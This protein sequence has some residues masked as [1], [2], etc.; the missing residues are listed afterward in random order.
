MNR[1]KM[2]LININVKIFIVLSLVALFLCG[3]IVTAVT[4]IKPEEEWIQSRRFLWQKPPE[5]PPVGGYPVLFILHGSSCFAESWFWAGRGLY[6]GAFI[7][8]RQQTKFVE[9]ALERGYF[10]IASDSSYLSFLST[11]VKA[12]DASTITFNES[13]DLPFIQGILDWLVDHPPTPVNISRLYCA[14]FSSGG[15]MTSRIAHLFGSRFKAVAIH[16]ATNANV[17]NWR[18]DF[19]SPQNF[20]H[21]HPPTLVIQGGKDGMMPAKAAIHFYEELQKNGISSKLLYKPN[22]H[23]IWYSEFNNQI[24]DWFDSN[25]NT[26]AENNHGTD[27]LPLC[28]SY[29]GTIL[30]VGGSGPN[31][32]SKIQDAI[33]NASTGDTVFVYDD[34]S[35]Y[36]ENIIIQKGVNLIGEN[37]NSTV[38]DGSENGDVINITADN[39]FLSRFTVQNCG[40]TWPY[41]EIHIYGNKCTITDNIITHTNPLLNNTLNI[42]TGI[43]MYKTSQNRITN[44]IIS[45]HYIGILFYSSTNLLLTDNMIKNSTAG[46]YLQSSNNNNTI[47]KNKII[48]S[49]EEGIYSHQ[50]SFNVITDNTM[51]NNGVIGIDL[52]ASHGNN[53]SMNMIDNHDKAIACLISD[54]NSFYR[55]ILSNSSLGIDIRES[56][57]N[58]IM[59]N[60][61]IRNKINAISWTQVI[62][63]FSNIWDRNYW[64]RPRVFPKPIFSMIRKDNI[65]F[66]IPWL[67][68]DWHPAKEPYAIPIG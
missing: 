68:F 42:Y 9:K 3:E 33:D 39:V 10:V 50:S 5:L 1:G 51:L 12:W 37:E 30:Y 18:T 46:I 62:Q 34:L 35:P 22:G 21:D 60:N 63:D 41:A 14:G 44:N 55:N 57:S 19:T 52:Y 29:N 4:P 25:E 32:Y 67:F 65:S 47:S 54:N 15:F 45:N 56:V 49:I 28:M 26:S 16:S 31:N 64:E 53:I 7:W 20:S 8:G 13:I 6:K 58:Y 59:K 40:K 2:K 17:V 61:F 36:K 43:F 24:L 11:K 66:S 27:N 23:H 48:N 38:I